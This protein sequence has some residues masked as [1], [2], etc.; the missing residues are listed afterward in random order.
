MD[1]KLAIASALLIGLASV[2]FLLITGI[3]D[4]RIKTNTKDNIEAVSRQ[5]EIADLLEKAN[6]YREAAMGTSDSTEIL[7]AVKAS[8][9][10]IQKREEVRL[11]YYRASATYALNALLASKELGSQEG[12]ELFK[13]IQT[14]KMDDLKKF[15]VAYMKKA[16]EATYAL[17]KTIDDKKTKTISLEKTKSFLWYFCFLFHSLGMVSAL[18]A[19][20]FKKFN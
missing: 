16:A 13:R 4:N 15:Y 17:Q 10:V 8:D 7:K 12:E 20:I 19:I 11:F 2:G 18:L 6:S 14:Q 3:F 9:D 1:K 5:R